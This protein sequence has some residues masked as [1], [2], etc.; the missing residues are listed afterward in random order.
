MSR[1]VVLH[2]G[3]N[4]VERFATTKVRLTCPL[5]TT[6]IQVAMAEDLPVSRVDFLLGNDLAEGKV[7]VQPPSSYPVPNVEAAEVSD[8]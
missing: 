1:K 8:C 2:Q 4:A 5:V 6:E 7:W 3:I